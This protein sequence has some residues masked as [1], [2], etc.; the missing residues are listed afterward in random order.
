MAA[1]SCTE[2]LTNVGSLRGQRF[3]LPHINFLR[4]YRL[5]T[6]ERAQFSK[7]DSSERSH[8]KYAVFISLNHSLFIFCS[9]CEVSSFQVPTELAELRGAPQR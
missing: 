8:L 5:Q 7:R 4:Y 1:G 6:A 2:L 9:V 3:F